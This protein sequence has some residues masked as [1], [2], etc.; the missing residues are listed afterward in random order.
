MIFKVLTVEV[1]PA[2]GNPAYANKYF[3]AENMLQADLC[4]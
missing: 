3:Q 2:W 4:C 1:V